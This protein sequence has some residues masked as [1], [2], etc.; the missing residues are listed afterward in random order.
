MGDLK[1]IGA[2][3]ILIYYLVIL[4]IFAPQFNA[5]DTMTDAGFNTTSIDLDEID[6]TEG[7]AWDYVRL[8]GIVLFGVG[9]SDDTPEWFS[10]FFFLWQ[11]VITISFVIII[12]MIIFGA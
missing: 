4:A 9:L 11:T 3:G 5:P 8:T 12:L 1:L 2:I 10:F 7:S 6:V